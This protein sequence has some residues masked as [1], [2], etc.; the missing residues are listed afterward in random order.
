LIELLAITA[1]GLRE[2]S[3]WLKLEKIESAK[4]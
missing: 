2:L 1:V 3:E 4:G